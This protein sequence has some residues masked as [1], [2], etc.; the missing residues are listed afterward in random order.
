MGKDQD[1]VDAET[2]LEI[3]QM[4][5]AII[6]A[7]TKLFTDS[8]SHLEKTLREHYDLR[9]DHLE[10]EQERSF[11]H[12]TEHFDAIRN[13]QERQTKDEGKEEGKD[14]TNAFVEN[15]KTIF[16]TAAAVLVT[17]AIFLLSP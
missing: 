10:K 5:E 14:K 6:E 16:W 3:L 1:N 9:L 2:K 11:R 12:H 13:L 8:N 4:K 15:K 17:I 7:V